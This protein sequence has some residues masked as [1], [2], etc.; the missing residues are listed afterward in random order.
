MNFYKAQLFLLLLFLTL[1]KADPALCGS[2]DSVMT[3]IQFQH[4]INNYD[5]FKKKKTTLKNSP[6][7]KYELKMIEA[8][9]SQDKVDFG[10]EFDSGREVNNFMGQILVVGGGKLKGTYGENQG[11]TALL[12]FSKEDNEIVDLIHKL[13]SGEWQED[14]YTGIK[15]NNYKDKE[16][17]I[18]ELQRK[19][20]LYKKAFD[21][22]NRDT[23]ERYYTLNIA[24][25]VQPDILASIT[26][27]S[28]M[29][30]IPDHKFARV[31]FENVPCPVFL[32][33]KLYK[34]LSRITK[35]GGKIELSVTNACRRLIAPVIQNT[36]F[37]EE[38][39]KI[40]KSQY[41][42]LETLHPTYHRLTFEIT[43]N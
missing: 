16:A 3:V 28:D 34:I 9:I 33:P 24:K 11:K 7:D 18:K 5:F 32:N 4:A 8:A 2:R 37:G 19:Q 15:F 12:D 23:L 20:K 26:S 29:K 13:Q 27:E 30:K 42:L 22:K 14:P 1:S 35:P 40:L 6:L 10:G 25:D 36:K 31:E 43:N 41:N 17:Y 38:Y 21:Q 39:S